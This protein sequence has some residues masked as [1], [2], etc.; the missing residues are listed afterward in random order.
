VLQ[1]PVPID[2]DLPSAA[3][4]EQSGIHDLW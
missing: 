3:I 4:G 1:I 2:A